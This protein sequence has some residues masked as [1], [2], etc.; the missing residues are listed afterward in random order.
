MI[1]GEIYAVKVGNDIVPVRILTP[2]VRGGWIGHNEKTG[3]DIHI[4]TAAKLRYKMEVGD[5]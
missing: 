4:K 2:S 5:D 1:S 3:R